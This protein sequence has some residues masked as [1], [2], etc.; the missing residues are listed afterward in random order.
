MTQYEQVGLWDHILETKKIT[1]PIKLIEMFAGIGS[2]RE[3]L[4]R[5]GFTIK[6]SKIIEWAVPSIQTYNDIHE[7]DYF[8]YSSNKTKEE[9]IEYLFKKGISINYNEPIK[10]KQI[11]NKPEKWIRTVY[12]NIIA[13]HNLVNISSVKAEDLDITETNSFEYILTYS[14]PCQD[15]SMAG[16]RAGLN[17]QNETR[18]GL[19][20]EV[21]RLLKEIKEKY[22]DLPQILLMEN[23]PDLIGN[24]F[25]KDFQKWELF[26]S[27]LG[28]S[29]FVDIL[30]AKD[31]GIPQ[32]RRRVFML[33][34]LGKYNY[35]FPLKIPLKLRLQ[36]LLEEKVD[37]KYYINENTLNFLSKKAGNFNR[38]KRFITNLNREN[39]DI[40][41]TITTNSNN[42]VFNN[43]VG[44]TIKFVDYLIML[45]N[46]ELE[47]KG[48]QKIFDEDYKSLINNDN[49]LKEKTK[50]IRIRN[51]TPK[52]CYRLM[53][54]SDEAFDKAQAN[55]SNSALYHQA[56]DSI[57]VNV[58]E[59][60][61]KQLKGSL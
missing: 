34:I 55:Q 11:Q 15:L 6:S 35:K 22:N 36:D 60:I 12:N 51:I 39:Q 28:Y 45:E 24:D 32:N 31:Y 33:S 29:N 18:S 25:I 2:Q 46:L 59:A 21:E 7:Q 10:L 1:K 40:A 38:R 57:V 49:D 37:E 58:L 43:Y 14:F 16:N 20:W 42:S 52:E 23:V 56:G 17:K 54:F 41:N 27:E 61:F 5:T 53:G 9:L 26:L 48:T 47:N 8:D 13:T 3:A 30:N 4:K 44:D 19:L 50:N